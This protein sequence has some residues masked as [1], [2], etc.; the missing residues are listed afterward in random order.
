MGIGAYMSIAFIGNAI[1]E[2]QEVGY[3]ST[4]HLIG[5]VPRLD[6]NLASMT[7]IHPTLE[8]IIAQ[9][10]LLAIYAV[11]SLYVLII[12]PTQQR[13]IETARKSR[14]DLVKQDKTTEEGKGL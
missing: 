11:G 6:I 2:F 10:I 8:T 9:I 14:E 7:G 1:R 5:I 4:T 13:L 12:R 3:I